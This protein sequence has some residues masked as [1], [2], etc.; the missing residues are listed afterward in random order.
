MLFSK[1]FPVNPRTALNRPSSESRS[2]EAESVE[3]PAA[4]TALKAIG[5]FDL[6]AA[7]E[8]P[9]LFKEIAT[10]SGLPKATLHRMLSALLETGLIGFDPN[11]KSYWLGMRILDLA[12]RIWERIDLSGAFGVELAHLRKISGETAH[13][14][15]L[16]GFQI[17][18]VDERSE[19]E[20]IRIFYQKGRRL[21]AYCTATGKAI[22]SKLDMQFVE[23][24][25]RRNTLHTYSSG[26][27][28]TW[29]SL[30]RE[31]ALSAER[32]YAVDNEEHEI[33]RRCVAAAIF[34]HRGSPIAAIGITGSSQRLSLERCHLLAPEVIAAAARITA[35]LG[36]LPPTDD[37]QLTRNRPIETPDVQC[38][39]PGTCFL[40]DSP[41]WC[42][43]SGRLVWVDILAPAV[44][45]ADPV[46]GDI[47]TSDVPALIGSLAPTRSGSFVAALQN[48]FARLDNHGRWQSGIADPEADKPQNRFNDGKCD[49]QGRFWAGTMSM[50]REPG[51]ASLYRLDQSGNVVRMEDGLS[52]CNGIEWSLD[53]KTMYVVD[54]IA[55]CIYAYDF[56]GPSGAISNRR[57]LVV[58]PEA[59]GLLGGLAIDASGCLFAPIWD[60][61]CVIRFTP[62]GNIDRRIDLP[63]PRPMGVC[64]GGEDYKTLFVTSA[65]LRMT[66]RQLAE[67]PLSGSVFALNVGIAGRPANLF[68]D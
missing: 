21:P 4:A 27:L 30:Q 50:L 12:N 41:V 36:S 22:L 54:S 17:T 61:G 46:S 16:E 51:Q 15:V 33:G 26:T 56:D 67:A 44:H 13:A 45:F 3:R 52:L 9:L 48:G 55:A 35:K 43:T 25:I 28:T 6:I 63:V 7:S 10:R 14:A 65:R 8:R 42:P 2:A 59:E 49:P 62:D 11:T 23:T 38:V 24:L 1:K 68:Q 58:F 5:I 53:G 57:I 18:Y 31:L 40:P 37:I 39:F 64:F 19:L 29:P 20:E 66:A 47:R 60:G 34:D 32:Q